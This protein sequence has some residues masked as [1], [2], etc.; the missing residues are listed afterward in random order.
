MLDRIEDA[1]ADFKKGKIVIVVDDENRENEGDFI[2]AGDNVTPEIINFMA[3]EGRGLICVPISR[4]ISDR[5]NL[6]PMT[7]E[8]KEVEGADFRVSIDASCG[9]KTG[10]SA[11]DRAVTIKK[12]TDTAAVPDDFVRPGHVFP[13]VAKD[14]GVLKRAGHTEAA[15]DL[16]LLSGLNPVAAIC[17]IMLDNG[18]MARLPDLKKIAKK[19]SLKLISIESLIQYRLKTEKTVSEVTSFDFPTKHGY[20]KG[21]LFQTI[22]GKEEHLALIAGDITGKRDVLVRVHSECLTGDALHSLRCD[23]GDQLQ[24]ALQMIAREGT[25]VL[26]Y[27]RQ[28]GRGIGLHNKLIAYNLQDKGMDTVEANEALGFKADQRNYG[29]G[30]Q[31]LKALGLKTIRQITNNPR[32]MIGLK[33]YGLEITERVPVIIKP[34]RYNEK[35]LRTKKEKLSH[36]LEEDRKE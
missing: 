13:L 22:D 27:M 31:I 33:G 34:N 7:S 6:P 28:E 17:E 9:I 35:Y 8:P 29:V 36:L 18:E 11:K 15:V 25:G 4:L 12:L 19:F 24:Y 2:A 20:F 16:C 10:I 21:I 5:V 32:K 14:F 30:A 3:K 1:I 26:L 23:C